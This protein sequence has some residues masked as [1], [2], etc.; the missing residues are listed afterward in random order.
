MANLSLLSCILYIDFDGLGQHIGFG[1]SQQTLHV[2]NKSNKRLQ[3]F[4][5][6]N[7]GKYFEPSIWFHVYSVTFSAVTID[8]VLD[9]LW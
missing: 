6:R 1:P 9:F 4:H 2:L 7:E 5:G 3:K 8:N